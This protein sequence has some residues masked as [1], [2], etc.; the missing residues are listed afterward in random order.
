MP[1]FNIT[2]ILNKSG[3]SLDRPRP[4]KIAAP[5]LDRVFVAAKQVRPNPSQGY[6]MHPSRRWRGVVLFRASNV[7]AKPWH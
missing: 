1:D 6:A 3:P 2:V 4:E 5:C 7:A